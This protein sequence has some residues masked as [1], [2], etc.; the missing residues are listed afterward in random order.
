M[1]LPATKPFGA[2][3]SRMG[4]LNELRVAFNTLIPCPAVSSTLELDG[5]YHLLNREFKCTR[6]S[7]TSR[8]PQNQREEPSVETEIENKCKIRLKN[9][10]KKT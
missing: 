8:W 7:R 5:H 1:R 4:L 10:D 3:E 6:G 9:L 2:L